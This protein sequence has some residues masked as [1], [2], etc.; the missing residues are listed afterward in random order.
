MDMALFEALKQACLGAY[1]WPTSH[2]LICSSHLAFQVH[3]HRECCT[4]MHVFLL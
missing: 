4:A 2:D 3:R 1:S